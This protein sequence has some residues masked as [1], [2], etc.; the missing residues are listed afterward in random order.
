MSADGHG[1]REPGGRRPRGPAARMLGV[2]AR[3]AERLAGATGVDRAL[4]DAAEEAIVRALR[5]PAV[6][7]A[8]V[9]AL[10]EGTAIQRG[11][12]EA[13]PSDAV[14]EA[15]VRTLATEVADRVWLEILARPTAQ[16]LVERIAET[17]EVRAA[18]VQ[19]GVGLVTDLGRRLTILTERLD[20]AIEELVQRFRRRPTHETETTEVGIAT[21]GVAAVIDLAL[22]TIVLS[23]SSGLLASVIPAISGGSNGLSV[24]GVVTLSLTGVIIGGAIFVAF[25]SLVG[26]TPGM[27]L[28][29]IRLDVDGSREV[30]L[31]R[32]IRR[33]LVVP[34]SVLVLGLG[35][36]NIV[37]SPRRRGWHDV[38]AGTTVVYD[39]R[40]LT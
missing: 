38:A 3:G 20:D 12:E 25:W 5:S 7:R 31:R 30:V 35:Y 37:V 15:G 22:I 4:E 16:M 24:W 21:R 6:E 26:Q 17:P 2:G 34:V 39:H 33:I 13:L 29:S 8:I 36:L 23:I 18:I 1:G 9:R 40:D 14:A 28:L 19:Q 32:A 27:R 10:S 11:V